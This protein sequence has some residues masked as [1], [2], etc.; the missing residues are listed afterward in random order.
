MRRKIANSSPFLGTLRSAYRVMTAPLRRYM[1]WTL[2]LMLVNLGLEFLRIGSVIPF[3]AHATGQPMEFPVPVIQQWIV[4]IGAD[5]LLGASILFSLTVIVL[6]AM[7]MVLTWHTSLFGAKFGHDLASSIYRSKMHQSYSEHVNQHSSEI[8]SGIGKVGA[9]VYGVA[10]PAMQGVVGAVHTVGLIAAV[11]WLTSPLAV[12]AGTAVLVGAYAVVMLSTRRTL[13]LFSR[14][15]ARLMRLLPRAIQDGVTGYRE[16]VMSQSQALYERQ[17]RSVDWRYRYTGVISGMISSSPR[18]IIEPISVL[19]IVL[20]TVAWSRQAGGLTE[21]LPILTALVLCL[22]RLLPNLQQTWT[23]ISSVMLNADQVEDVCEL[24]THTEA[25][26]EVQ[27]PPAWRFSDRLGLDRVEFRYPGE[28]FALAPLSLTIHRGE[29]IGICGPTGGGKSTL[30]DLIIGLLEPS[31]GELRVDGQPMIA[32]TRAA[33]QAGVA[34]VPQSIFLTD[35]SIAE[36][37]AFSTAS[38]RP[39]IVRAQQAAAQAC[40]GD[41]LETLP[42]GIHTRVGEFGSRLSGGQRQRIGIARALYRNPSVLILDEAT[43]A[44]DPET[45]E[46]LLGG[47]LRAYPDLTMIIVSHRPSTL[48]VCDRVLRI[49]AGRLVSDEPA[50]VAD[51]A[52]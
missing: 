4:A 44:L 10:Q 5:T 2:V 32:E 14:L 46:R 12:L 29:R 37:I 36:N 35:S 22:Q 3:I 8:Y 51:S 23:G 15:T 49:A 18:M 7:R 6:A 19:V 38:T 21:V 52:A 39:D 43:S 50:N 27:L 45:E 48:S 28:G 31:R 42:H 1:W 17:F 26:A 11:A 33:W 20:A 25:P 47:L 41:F 40:L 24:I 16:V 13:T 30:L 34:I 9:L